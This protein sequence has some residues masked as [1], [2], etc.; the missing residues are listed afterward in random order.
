MF[1]FLNISLTDILFKFSCSKMCYLSAVQQH[2]EK[3]C[4]KV[5]HPFPQRCGLEQCECMCE[6]VH[7]SLPYLSYPGLPNVLCV[8]E[9]CTV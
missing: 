5:S 8:E 9:L 1:N 2:L 3:T 6:R 4:S 7:V